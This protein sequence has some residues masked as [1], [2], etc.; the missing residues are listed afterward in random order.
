MANLP[1]SLDANLF[2]YSLNFRYSDNY[3]SLLFC[4]SALS[5]AVSSSLPLGMMILGL[6][7]NVL[8]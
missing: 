3:L 5:M 7:M 1:L 8:V 2:S 6:C 4:F